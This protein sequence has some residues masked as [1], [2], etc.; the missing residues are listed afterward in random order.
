MAGG[1][2]VSPVLIGR[3][4]ELDRLLSAVTAP[5]AVVTVRGEAG[6]G[7]S[8][9]V[10]ELAGHAGLSGRRLITGT[11]RRI[12]EPFPLGPLI[13][14]ITEQEAALAGASLSPVAGA[15]R[16]LVPEVAHVLPPQPTPLEDRAAER[17]RVFRG[18]VEVISALCPSVLVV[19]DLHWADEQSLELIGYLLADPPPGLAVVLT[20][21]DE[22]DRGAVRASVATVSA[23]VRRSELE[24]APLDAEQT[25]EL[26]AAILGQRY[27]PAELGRYVWDRTSGVP[28]AVEELL[29]LLQERGL[30]IFRGGATAHPAL[31]E[32]D[33]PA[34]V[35]D[36]VLERVGRLSEQ[37]R[38]VAEAAAVLQA[39][40][41]VPVL[42]A[43]CRVAGGRA[44]D[45][46]DEALAAGVLVETD[47]RISFRHL[48]AARAVYEATPVTRRQDLHSR[49]V[50][51]LEQLDPAP[52]GRLA[53]HLWCSGRTAEWAAVAECAA[54]R[55]AELGHDA[56]AARLLEDVLRHA[57]LDAGDRGRLAVKLA[58]ASTETVGVS[59][60]LINLLSDVVDDDLL[61]A[62]RG[63]L[64]LR[65]ALLHEAAGSAPSLVRGFYVAAAGDLE[66]R[67]D[68][69]AWAMMGLGIHGAPG[70]ALAEHRHWLRQVLDLLPA[71]EPPSFR[72]FLLGKVVMMLATTGDPDWRRLSRELQ[73][74]TGGIARTRRAVNA[75]Q[76][77]G[78]AACYAG[79]HR[80]A[81]RLLAHAL[82]GALGADS[83]KLELRVRSALALLDYCR[84]RWDQLG[85]TVADLL[86]EL[87]GY[88]L[89]RID[90]EAVAG[91]LALARGDVD[92]A[93]QRLPRLAVE[94]TELGGFELAALAV[95]ALARLGA[96]SGAPGDAIKCVREF[97]DTM[98]T[99]GFWLPVVRVL[100]AITQ[101]LLTGGMPAEG[102]DLVRRCSAELEGLDAPLGPAATRHAQALLDA[103][104]GRWQ[105]AAR[106]FLDAAGEYDG[107]E[108]R[109]EAAQAREQAAGALL[110]LGDNRGADVL[111]DALVAYRSLEAGWDLDRAAKTARRHGVS[112]PG[113]HRGGRRGYA[114][115]LSPRE[116]EVAALAATGRTNREIA[117]ELFLSPKTVEKHV[118]AALRKLGVRSRG[119]LAARLADEAAQKAKNGGFTP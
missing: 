81:D 74:S 109:Y 32:L 21:R 110:Q 46:L 78:M 3:G 2:V 44:R 11:C 90:V 30:S 35:R 33:V 117:R 114:T 87:T 92:G 77:A 20:S 50:G 41:S 88:P 101:V 25:G 29:A 28:F 6:I 70:I 86:D 107:L 58:R 98:Q 79:H 43:T 61:A 17:H 68:L 22:D 53:R 75:Y 85:P 64:N 52:L 103:A 27:I 24:L 8:R 5:P 115:R 56:E 49:A 42:L 37:A 71:V 12:R 96:V 106:S 7:K 1:R 73:A 105:V 93:R 59:S 16:P 72:V 31:H 66:G 69:Q 89:A 60:E 54:D 38:A 113:R 95:G 45:G 63:E 83:R 62:T 51:S 82:E 100:P 102:Q 91:C 36:P 111:R 112:V 55:A 18:I 97:L 40:A 47:G 9:L 119:A 13:E 104:R 26:T 19:E 67:P 80:D 14:A 84:G 65:L 34:G 118:G 10:A 94:A 15:L 4:I 39:P 57:D 23:S 48:L 76:S 99:K 108:C 116:R